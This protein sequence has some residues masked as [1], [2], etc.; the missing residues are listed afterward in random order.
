MKRLS[1]LLVLAFMFLLSACGGISDPEEGLVM[2]FA[3]CVLETGVVMESY[4]R[5]CEYEGELFIEEIVEIEVDQSPN[6]NEEYAEMIPFLQGAL[7]WYMDTPSELDVNLQIV[8]DDHVKGTFS[9]GPNEPQ[10]NFLALWQ[11]GEWEVV[12]AA[13]AAPKC[14]DMSDYNF[15]SDMIVDCLNG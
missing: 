13:A 7:Q 9:F 5:Q 14:D 10:L 8:A 15:P 11:F 4:P 12:H 1:F 2:T 6:L 3:D